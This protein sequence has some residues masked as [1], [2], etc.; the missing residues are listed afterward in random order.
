MNNKELCWKLLKADREEEVKDILEKYGYWD[1]P[2]AWRILGDVENNYGTAGNQQSSPVAALIEKITNS[3]DARL[4]NACLEKGIRPESPNAPGTIKEAVGKFF[5]HRRYADEKSGHLALWDESKLRE[6]GEKITLALTGEAYKTKVS[7]PSISVADAGEGQSPDEF[8]NTLCSLNKTNK[9]KINFVY[10]RFNM[11]G[12]GALRFCGKDAHTQMLISRRNPKFINGSEG[13]DSEWGFTIIR[14]FHPKEGERS[15]IYKYLAPVVSENGNQVLS[16]ESPDF[17]IFPKK[18][19]AYSMKSE[20]GTLVKLYE[21]GLKQTG[22]TMGGGNAIIKSLRAHLPSPALPFRVYECRPFTGI[23]SYRAQNII[24]LTNQLA[25]ER[26]L[27]LFEE[28]FEPHNGSMAIDYSEGYSFPVKIYVFKDKKKADEYRVASNR[29]SS[30]GVIIYTFNGQTHSSTSI[31]LIRLKKLGLAILK[32]YL[33]VI[34][35]CTSISSRDFEDLFMAS[36]DR[37]SD[38]KLKDAIN[39]SLDEWLVSIS[40]LKELARRRREELTSGATSDASLAKIVQ[41]AVPQDMQ[42]WL[43]TGKS[44]VQNPDKRMEKP[45]IELRLKEYPTYFKFKKSKSSPGRGPEGETLSELSRELA[46]NSPLYIYCETDANNDYLSD[47]GKGNYNI[48]DENGIPLRNLWTLAGPN[49]GEARFSLSRENTKNFVSGNR[50]KIRF[51][52]WDDNPST[53]SFIN[54]LTVRVKEEP[55]HSG[56]KAPP[57]LPEQPQTSTIPPVTYVEKKDWSDHDFTELS[58]GSII[59]KDS[60]SDGFAYDLFLNVNNKF[61]D[62]GLQEEAKK[63]NGSTESIKRRFL[64]GMT[65]VMVALVRRYSDLDLGNEEK[66]E[67]YEANDDNRGYMDIDKFVRDATSAIAFVLLP[68]ITK[69]SKYSQEDDSDS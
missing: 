3:I 33:L 14:R 15:S 9:V 47:N 19:K 61:L 66:R 65:L 10:G 13:R 67:D 32:D 6:E 43:I 54:E 57:K 28:S 52:I 16:F 30:N 60:N 29:G 25:K 39:K 17:P 55:A 22:V 40:A 68:I 62:I 36:R 4:T 69:I 44:E 35:D 31:G 48:L 42:E 12:T 18:D 46:P 53:D 41:D 34:V 64:A 21:Y 26:N 59:P 11:G 50:F 7:L 38:C 45:K 2:A 1:D 20:H 37:M 58:A 63:A 51:V 27:K 49:Q 23:S 56:P 5:E 8:P 24:G